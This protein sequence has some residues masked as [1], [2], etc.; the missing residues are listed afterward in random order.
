VSW[1]DVREFVY[2]VVDGYVWDGYRPYDL[3]DLEDHLLDYAAGLDEAQLNMHQIQL[4]LQ[5]EADQFDAEQWCRMMDE[6]EEQ[7]GVR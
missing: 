4:A 6:Q 2:D 7:D 1:S 3:H 5:V